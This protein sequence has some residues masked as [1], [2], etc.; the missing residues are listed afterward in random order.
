MANQDV[1]YDEDTPFKAYELAKT[2]LNDQDIAKSL[3]ISRPTLNAWRKKRKVLDKAIREGR[4]VIMEGGAAS[5][6]DYVHQQLPE[7]LKSYWDALCALD[8]DGKLSAEDIEAVLQDA[9]LRGRQNLWLHALIHSNFNPSDACRKVN[10]SRKT[11]SHWLNDRHFREL[12]QEIQW[13]KKNF[14]EGA[15]IGLVASGDTSATIF[16]NKTVNRDRGYGERIKIDHEH[17]HK[18]E[19]VSM[20][21]ILDK[22][23]LETKKKMLA[24]MRDVQER[25]ALPPAGFEGGDTIDAEW[26]VNGEGE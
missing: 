8:K 20:Q 2:G 17:Q 14:F 16:V 22:V 19:V 15:L 11:V 10:V 7:K 25:P 4:K 18:V 9:G 6:Q 3:G 13:H 24:A 5:F 21:Q 1:K 23:D 12:F 26:E